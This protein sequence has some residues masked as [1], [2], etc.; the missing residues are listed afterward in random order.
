MDG[1]RFDRVTRYLASP[2][3]RRSTMRRLLAAAGALAAAG[4][5]ATLVVGA[6]GMLIAFLPLLASPIPSLRDIGEAQAA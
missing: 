5:P 1:K 6:F 3:T 2:Q 4:L